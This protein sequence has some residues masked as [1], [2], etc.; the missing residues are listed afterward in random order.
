[1]EKLTCLERSLQ[2]SGSYIRYEGKPFPLPPVFEI[3][4]AEEPDKK[5]AMQ[6]ISEARQLERQAEKVYSSLVAECSDQ[7]GRDM[8]Q[9][10][11]DEE[12]LHYKILS[13]AYR[14]L[15]NTG[16]WSWTRP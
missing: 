14:S 9:K 10:L 4:A 8:F 1:M 3:K 5:S 16:K 11:A 6:V 13:D 15:N 7:Q 2:E 12:H